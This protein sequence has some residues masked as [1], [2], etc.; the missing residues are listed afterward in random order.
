MSRLLG[1]FGN[2]ERMTDDQIER[3]RDSVSAR[4]IALNPP[5]P[6]SEV[7]AFEARYGIMLPEGYRRFVTEIA[8]GGEGPP[9]SGIFSLLEPRYRFG[10]E[11]R[12]NRLP[13]IR[14]P[15]PLTEKWIWEDD[16]DT[17]PDWLPRRQAVYHG[18]IQIGDDGC[19]MFWHLIVT[20][21][22]RGNVW[23]LCGEG[24]V[25]GKPPEFL[26]WYESWLSQ[27]EKN[28]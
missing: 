21:S 10:R 6:L 27:R 22:E 26:A 17:S 15:F 7:E 2:G 18:S 24:A 16:D 25:P 11:D 12:W 1:F 8:D 3:I 9:Q 13:D 19:G 23:D 5:L 28:P 4:G 20:G 14:L